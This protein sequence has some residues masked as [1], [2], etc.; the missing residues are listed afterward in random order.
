[1]GNTSNL[2]TAP[3]VCGKMPTRHTAYNAVPTSPTPVTN[4]GFFESRTLLFISL[5]PL[6]RIAPVGLSVPYCLRGAS[7]ISAPPLRARS[8]FRAR[9]VAGYALG[10]APTYFEAY[11]GAAGISS[12]R[13]DSNRCRSTS[14][15]TGPQSAEVKAI[16]SPSAGR[17][18]AK[19][20]RV[21]RPVHGA[22]PVHLCSPLSSNRDG[23]RGASHSAGAP[24]WAA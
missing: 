18:L 22:I 7:R 2:P 13:R 10:L 19:R 11:L 12:T 6:W 17:E 24:E 21:R 5:R 9:F 23:C 20:H 4:S 1:M 16:P 15:R 14:T 8:G 3:S